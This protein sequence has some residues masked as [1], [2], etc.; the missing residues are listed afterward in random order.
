MLLGL[1]VASLR[2]GTAIGG[3]V[4]T[5]VALSIAY[6][7][8]FGALLFSASDASLG[9]TDSLK[10]SWGRIGPLYWLLV[11]VPF[12]AVYGAYFLL[13]VPGLVITV[14][15][16]IGLFVFAREDLRG[17]SA[18]LKGREYVRGRGFPVFGR[19]A[20]VYALSVLLGLVPFVGGLLNLLYMPFMMIFICLVYEDLRRVRGRFA[21][22]AAAGSK[23]KWVALNVFGYVLA[24]LIIVLLSGAAIFGGLLL[25]LRS[26]IGL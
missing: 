26:Q 3:A 19:V 2:E 7:W 12:I 15:Y 23:A 11:F 8:G 18:L 5:V 1:S 25:M 4:V 10:A 21:F 22:S 13:I 14:W 6:C 24:P 17:L 9:F 16:F 20:A